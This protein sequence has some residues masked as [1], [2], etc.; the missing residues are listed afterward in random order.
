MPAVR[1][2]KPERAR[3]KAA[4]GEPRLCGCGV[5]V[6]AEERLHLINACAFFRAE[7]FREA[8]PGS[9]RGEDVRKAAREVDAA[10]QGRRRSKKR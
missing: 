4:T 9:I 5:R 1:V 7:R 10:L 2:R 6:D 3:T 8:D